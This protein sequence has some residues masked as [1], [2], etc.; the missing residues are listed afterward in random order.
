MGEEAG[1]ALYQGN[2]NA[3][4]LRLVIVAARVNSL[5]T[6]AL[7]A[8][9]RSGFAQAGGYPHNLS[10]AYVPGACELPQAA[11]ALAR[12]THIDALVALGAVIR[13][14]TPHFDFVAHTA[15]HGL[16][17]VARQHRIALGMGVLTTDTLAQ[18]LERA[19]GKGGNAG[20]TA[21]HSAIEMAHLLR[22]IRTQ[23]ETS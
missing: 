18:A 15:F 6:D 10:L 1:V 5:V 8:G 20:T 13:G 23:G 22:T 9:A 2:S 17:E 21:V 19:G 16:A 12:E 14:E 11:E 7:L 3:G 4:E